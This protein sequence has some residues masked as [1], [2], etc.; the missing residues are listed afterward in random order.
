VFKNLKLERPLAVLDLETTGKDPKTDHIVEISVRVLH[1]D[2][3]EVHRVRRL[4]PGV[5]I[6][7]EA[8]A[9]HGIT[10]ADVAA[11]PRFAQVAAGLLKLLD[12][13]DLA[14]YNLEKFDL[15]LLYAEFRRAGRTLP[16]DGRAVVDVMRLFHLCEP[17]DLSAAVK[18]FLRRDHV[19]AHSAEADTQA[20]AEVLDAMLVRYPDLPRTVAELQQLL[21]SPNTVD[22]SGAFIRVNGEVRCTLPKHRGRPLD[23]VAATDPRYLE[24]MLAEP[25][26]DDT[27]ALVREALARCGAMV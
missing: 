2:G 6:P 5:P 27:K 3:R 13:C 11:E 24:W 22:S 21:K 15:R 12:G 23:F 14:G 16:L 26:F 25:F 8:T 19:H 10:D 9:V 20:T 7:P 17:R 18:H 4:N 1:P